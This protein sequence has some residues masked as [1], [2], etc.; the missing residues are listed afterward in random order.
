MIKL[1]RNL[2]F[3]VALAFL[4]LWALTWFQVNGAVRDLSRQA[5]PMVDVAYDSVRVWPNGD[6][7]I[8]G[9]TVSSPLDP[10]GGVTQIASLRFD[11]P[12]LLYLA[13]FALGSQ[14]SPPD[15]LAVTM[16][17][18]Q[19]PRVEVFRT[20]EGQPWLSSNS[21]VPF[22]T[23]GCSDAA[24]LST[25][26]Y[27]GMGLAP[28][29][30]SQTIGY[31]VDRR[32]GTLTVHAQ[33]DSQPLSRIDLE[34][35]VIGVDPNRLASL[36][37]N[38]IR[39]ERASLRY[40]DDGYLA[41]RNE[42]CA[43]RAGSGISR[44]LRA[45]VGEIEALAEQL[46]ASL[47]TRLLGIYR[48]LINEGGTA[49]LEIRPSA[50]VPFSRYHAYA[51]DDIL[52]LLNL[53]ARI[54]DSGS[55]PV[56]LRIAETRQRQAEQ[57]SDSVVTEELDLDSEQVQESEAAAS[58]ESPPQ[59]A[60]APRLSEQLESLFETPE[61]APRARQSRRADS[62]TVADV[63]AQQQPVQPSIP[64]PQPGEIEQSVLPTQT[65]RIGPAAPRQVAY[66]ELTSLMGRRITIIT[67]N[68]QRRVGTVQLIGKDGVTI[69]VRLGG[70][71]ATVTIPEQSIREIRYSGRS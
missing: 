29:Q 38:A 5:A 11:T 19:S 34:M 56:E 69:E 64:I 58:V 42:W 60:Q 66:S 67:V 45:H 27:L 71:I 18:L 6:V 26:D 47:D 46:G 9:L 59:T 2:L 44:F 24:V 10:E 39:V 41:R 55:I 23:F 8:K 16:Q 70:G 31:R 48:R 35:I 21:Y 62:E 7:I 37:P 43:A 20:A 53:T 49:V 12:G 63:P 13:R 57:H 36:D 51:P 14:R 33:L 40:H 54:S 28:P 3:G 1:L 22:E 61:P 15:Q 50:S 17:G 30:Q 32:N 25:S 52:R 68:G 65:T 4:L